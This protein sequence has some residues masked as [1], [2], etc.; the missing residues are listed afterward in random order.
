MNVRTKYK[1]LID[2]MIKFKDVFHPDNFEEFM[3]YYENENNLTEFRKLV[4]IEIPTGEN[5]ND[6][7]YKYIIK[8]NS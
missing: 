4:D 3:N 8:K 6:W 7:L 1:V 2:I 5:A